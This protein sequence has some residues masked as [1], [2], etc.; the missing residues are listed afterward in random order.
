MESYVST[1][2]NNKLVFGYGRLTIEDIV[3][4]VEKN[5]EVSL[6]DD[7]KKGNQSYN[8]PKKP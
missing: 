4:V 6:S 2:K 3:S 8:I 1:T 7:D 5:A